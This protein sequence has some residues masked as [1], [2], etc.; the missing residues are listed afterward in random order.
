VS[1]RLTLNIGL[2]W[3]VTLWPIY[4]IRGTPDSYV[5]DLNLNNGTYILTGVPAAC[6][7]TVGFPCI[8]GGVLPPNVVV[9]D[10]GSGAIYRNSYDNWQGRFGFGYRLTNRNAVRGG[11][12]R[13]YDNW[14][15]VI[16]LAQNYGGT[17]P[18]IAQLTASNLNHISPSVSIGD[19]LNLG[20]GSV[21]HPAANPFSQV[22]F[23]VDPTGY[24]LP[25]SDQWNLGFEQS[26]GANT[27]LSVAYVGSH[28]QRLN[29]GGVKNVARTP[30]PGDADTVAARRPYPYITPTF[31]DQSIGQ[32]SYNAL[33][34]RLDGR[35]SG[36]LAYLVSYTWSKSIDVACSGSFGVEGC[37][38][39]NP[40]NIN[41]DRSVSGFDIPQ[42]FSASWTWELPVG[43]GK[44]YAFCNSFVNQVA[45]NWQL[46]GIV[47]LYSG[48]PFDVTVSGDIANT[49][50]N[51]E[52]ADLVL[53]DPYASHKGPNGWV[54]PAAFRIPANF[55]FG[56]LGRNSLRTDW[57][58]NLDFSIFRRFP[59]KERLT[60]EF[61]AEAFN[62]TNTPVFG[63][64]DSTINGPTF[65]A[66][67]S[68]LN[69]SREVQF[70]LKA[71]F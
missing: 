16:Q 47:S 20:S 34:A 23:F 22:A 56:N 37:G 33:Q 45:A 6:S 39:Q 14:N 67:T 9:T 52:R 18:N 53:K 8:P 5:G 48:V 27:V 49:G 12:G 19:P 2:R 28:S 55:T 24:K 40:Y 30:G 42:N 68:T 58:K 41:A 46:N 50:N 43:K 66:I 61:R 13:F 4:G 32:S 29:L 57:M 36:G 35:G 54:N 63:Q 3:D 15:S 38:L 44:R 7:S 62:A 25:H 65:G 26:V 11:Y 31:Y 70:A 1:K 69:R 59:I 51:Y 71:L 21:Q 17:W 10:R 60:F 64:P